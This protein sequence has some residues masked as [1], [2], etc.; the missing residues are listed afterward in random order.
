MCGN[1]GPDLAI[2][3]LSAQRIQRLVSIPQVFMHP[4]TSVFPS[5][6]SD[7]AKFTTVALEKGRQD[8]RFPGPE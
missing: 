5:P 1:L 2:L 7:L 6:E 3:D 8:S 4:F